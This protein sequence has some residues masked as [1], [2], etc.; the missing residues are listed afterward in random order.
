MQDRV[1]FGAVHA[2]RAGIVWHGPF[3]EDGCYF[4]GPSWSLRGRGQ[5]ML[6]MKMRK[7]RVVEREK[8]ELEQ[9]K[10]CTFLKVEINRKKCGEDEKEGVVK[11]RGE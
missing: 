10:G 9:E 7:R 2:P 11:L 8:E 1:M 4:L 3:T 6:R 5:H